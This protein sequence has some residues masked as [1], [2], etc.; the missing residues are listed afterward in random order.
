MGKHPII[1]MRAIEAILAEYGVLTVH[2]MDDERG[3]FETACLAD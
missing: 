2:A 1:T 3:P